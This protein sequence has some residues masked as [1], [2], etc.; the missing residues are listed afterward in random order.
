MGGGCPRGLTGLQ[1]DILFPSNPFV[2]GTI[3]TYVVPRIPSRWRKGKVSS[4]KGYSKTVFYVYVFFDLL[5]I[6]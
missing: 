1:C 6:F 5:E 3:R 4:D 2:Y